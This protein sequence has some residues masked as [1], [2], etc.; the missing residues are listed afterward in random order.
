MRVTKSF[1][2]I[3]PNALPVSPVSRVKVDT[4]FADAARQ[5]FCFVHFLGFAFG[6]FRFQIVELAQAS[7]A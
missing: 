7:P 6:A 5:I 1:A 4:Q 2:V 3:E